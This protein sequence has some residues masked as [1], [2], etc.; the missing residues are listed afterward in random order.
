MM[1]HLASDLPVARSLKTA[2]KRTCVAQLQR[3]VLLHAFAIPGL[4]C[5]ACLS[6]VAARSRRRRSVR[7]L[8]V[9]WSEPNAC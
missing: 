1:L 7:K 6:T 5:V 4:R 3:N 8:D 2:A 9:N